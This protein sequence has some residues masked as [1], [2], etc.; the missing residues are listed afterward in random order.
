[1]VNREDE[2]L[3]IKVS[4]NGESKEFKSE[5]LPTLD[6]LKSKIMGYLSIP[7]IKKYMHFSYRNKEDQNIIIENE[8]DLMKYSNQ[9]QDNESYLEIY[10]SIDNELKLIKEFMNS[11]QFNLNNHSKIDSDNIYQ[12][13]NEKE[14]KN[15]SEVKNNEKDKK[16]KIKELQNQINEIKKRREQKK[17]IQEMNNKLSQY[18]KK[19]KELDELKISNFIN[20]I[21][22][23]F[24]NKIKPL[25]EKNISDYLLKIK[26][27]K[28]DEYYRIPE[29]IKNK[30]DQNISNIY[31]KQNAEKMLILNNNFE[32]IIKDIDEIKNEINKINKN[33]VKNDSKEIQNNN[34]NNNI[35]QGKIKNNENIY[36]LEYYE[37]NTKKSIRIKRKIKSG[38]SSSIDFEQKNHSK[39]IIKEFNDM[40][41]EIFYNNL[42]YLINDEINKIKDFKYKLKNLKIDPLPIFKNFYNDNAQYLDPQIS[43]IKFNKIIDIISKSEKEENIGNSN[44]DNKIS[45]KG[46]IKT[47]ISQNNFKKRK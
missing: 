38:N 14:K 8:K 16:L 26:Y 28:F 37:N 10:L 13:P 5:N 29:Y 21:L 18:L 22:N 12:K 3:T 23:E 9:I 33:K 42:K 6:E 45:N 15:E 7:D 39:I 24:I 35:H 19:K 2:F 46:S 30:L 32:T 34:G 4:H 20:E 44:D 17:K 47:K 1:M 25:I 43:K 36:Y 27:K 41:E 40:L 31:M 11:T